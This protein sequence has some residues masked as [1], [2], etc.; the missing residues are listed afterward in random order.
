M[1]QS[2]TNSWRSRHWS[3]ISWRK[4]ASRWAFSRSLVM[5]FLNVSSSGWLLGSCVIVMVL[6]QLLTEFKSRKKNFMG[7][8]RIKSKMRKEESTTAETITTISWR[9]IWR[10]R[11]SVKGKKNLTATGVL[12]L[13]S[14]SWPQNSVILSWRMCVSTF[15]QPDSTLWPTP[16]ASLSPTRLIIRKCRCPFGFD[17]NF[18]NIHFRSLSN[19]K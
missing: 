4:L 7:S 3:T 14:I 17:S 13:W 5:E 2:F 8:W 15:G 12:E 9:L 19:R 16:L 10:N 6:M 1:K 18:G 11:S